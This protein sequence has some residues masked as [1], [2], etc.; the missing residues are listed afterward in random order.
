MPDN[1]DPQLEQLYNSAQSASSEGLKEEALKKCEEAIELLESYGEETERHSF[2]DFVM[3]MADIHWTA[4]DYEAA[5]GEYQRVANHDPERSDARVAM[6]VA[7]YHLCRF[8]ASQTILEMCSLEDPEDAEIW[9]Y[10]GLLAL[11]SEKRELA[12]NHFEL[13]HELQENRFLL[14]VEITETEITEIVQALVDEIPEAIRNALDNV[15]VILETRP[16]DELLFSSD[17]PIDPTV[18]GIFDGIP[19]I[20]ESSTTIHTAPTRI[21]LF[22]ENIWL[23]AGDRATLEEELWI[24]LKHEIGH[25]F[26]L[27]EEELAERGL[28]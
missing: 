14:P 11:R 9:Y 10:L 28:E 19:V 24:T 12:R 2:S 6:G 5:Y 7:L 25:Y 20:E 8:T 17:P 3:L 23:I 26:G 18:L 16:P 4:G 1:I 27:S 13:A 15:P 22:S 21:V